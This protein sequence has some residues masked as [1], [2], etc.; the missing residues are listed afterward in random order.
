MKTRTAWNLAL[1]SAAAIGLA[2]CQNPAPPAGSDPAGSSS[3]DA[4]AAASGAEPAIAAHAT[5]VIP[6][7]AQVVPGEGRFVFGP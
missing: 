2:A 3:T 6:R 7:P 4:P 1:A 5:A